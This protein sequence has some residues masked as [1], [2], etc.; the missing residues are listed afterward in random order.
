MIKQDESCYECTKYMWAEIHD[1]PLHNILAQFTAEV[2]SVNEKRPA[3]QLEKAF[4]P[5][6]TVGKTC[7]YA[8]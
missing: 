1:K 7:S 2:T 3:A 4:S 5:M 6:H 8:I